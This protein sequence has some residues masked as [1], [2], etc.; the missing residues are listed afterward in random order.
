MKIKEDGLLLNPKWHNGPFAGIL[1]SGHNEQNGVKLENPVMTVSVVTNPDAF[2]TI[3]INGL[4]YTFVAANADVDE[5]NIGATAALTAANIITK[6]N[7]NKKNCG[8]SAYSLGKDTLILLVDNLSEKNNAAPGWINDGAKVIEDMCWMNSIT[9]HMLY[10]YDYFRINEVTDTDAKP[11]VLATHRYG[12]A[13][14]P[15][16]QEFLY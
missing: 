14:A 4:T 7:S 3:G 16:Y 5:I 1:L 13:T 6:I 15:S 12:G 8:C 10:D 11:I 9:Q 2:E